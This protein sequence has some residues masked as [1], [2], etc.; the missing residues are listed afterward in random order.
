MKRTEHDYTVTPE[1]IVDLL[2]NTAIWS[3]APGSSTELIH[4]TNDRTVMQVGSRL[5]EGELVVHDTRGE[6][7]IHTLRQGLGHVSLALARSTNT[8]IRLIS[9]SRLLMFARRLLQ[10]GMRYL[11]NYIPWPLSLL[12]V[13]TTCCGVP[14]S[15]ARRT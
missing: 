11:W 4:V 15:R 8:L 1:P 2:S 14:G 9:R 13:I 10:K 12:P 3:I 5:G 6:R 7:H